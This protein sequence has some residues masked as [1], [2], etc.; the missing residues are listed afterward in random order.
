MSF[1]SNTTVLA[2][3]A[4]FACQTWATTVCELDGITRSVS[5]MYSEPGQPT[6]CE[7]LYEKNNEN[8]TMTLWRAQN[9]ANYCEARAAE[10]VQKLVDLNWACSA[11]AVNAN[12]SNRQTE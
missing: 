7:V 12:L 8:Q 9:E 11:E 5:I 4:L 6:P 1:I 2:G 3:A 10:F